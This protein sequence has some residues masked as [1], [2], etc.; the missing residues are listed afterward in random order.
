MWSILCIYTAL[1]FQNSN[2]GGRWPASTANK[3]QSTVLLC[4]AMTCSSNWSLSWPIIPGVTVRSS[5]KN[6]LTKCCL[7]NK[8]GQ[9][10]G[11]P[12]IT[13]ILD[14]RNKRFRN[15]NTCIFCT[16]QRGF[17]KKTNK[18]YS[19][20]TFVIIRMDEALMSSPQNNEQ[21]Y[22]WPDSSSW[23]KDKYRPYNLC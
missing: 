13:R 20:R 1:Q 15:L 21:W 19:K 11:L 7:W 8:L 2:T 4:Y 9:M 12:Y 6:N 16:G 14:R 17:W 3:P 23:R 22:S 5:Q 10:H 18:L